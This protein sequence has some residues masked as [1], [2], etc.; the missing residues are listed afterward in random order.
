MPV[1]FPEPNWMGGRETLGTGYQ[2]AMSVDFLSRGQHLRK[3]FGTKESVYIRK[4]SP[5]ELVWNTNMA[6]CHCFGTPAW[7]P[8][9]LCTNVLRRKKWRRVNHWMTSLPHFDAF[10]FPFFSKHKERKKKKKK[11]YLSSWCLTVREFVWNFG[12]FLVQ[13]KLY[14]SAYVLFLT[15]QTLPLNSRQSFAY[16][17]KYMKKQLFFYFSFYR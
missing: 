17:F 9:S 5:K 16:K 14:G 4:E 15:F 11:K 8:F 10:C 7:P 3:C 13:K 1:S 12:F 2:G 6:A